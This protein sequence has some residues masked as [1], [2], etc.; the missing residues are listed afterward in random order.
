MARWLAE[1]AARSARQWRPLR[2]APPASAFAVAVPEISTSTYDGSGLDPAQPDPSDADDPPSASAAAADPSEPPAAPDP[3]RLVPLDELRDCIFPVAD[4]DTVRDMVLAALALLGV[5]LPGAVAPLEAGLGGF[6][7]GAG[8]GAGYG[9]LAFL[10]LLPPA[11]AAVAAQRCMP[12]AAAGG[13]APPG[14]WF[15]GHES[16]RLFVARLLWALLTGGGP[17]DDHPQV[18]AHAGGGGGG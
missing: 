14:A 8:M 10:R 15:L 9:S 17:T 12:R 13:P 3:A 6:G 4:A 11:A 16:R 7:S 2:R 18:R 5:P 1:E